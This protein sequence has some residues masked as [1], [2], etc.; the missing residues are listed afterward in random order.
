M[1]L[2]AESLASHASRTWHGNRGRRFADAVRF[3]LRPM[4]ESLVSGNVW[5][6]Q[7]PVVLVHAASCKKTQ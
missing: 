1:W 2:A 5:G 7:G 4:V 6:V 3:P